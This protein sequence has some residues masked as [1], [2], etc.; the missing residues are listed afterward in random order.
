MAEY[1][2][3][4]EI[5]DLPSKGHFYVQGHPLSS[6]KVEIKYMT[7]K[8]EDILTSQNLI[9]KGVVIEKLLQSLIVDKSIKIEDLLIGDK[10]AIMVA[11]RV[12]GYGKNYQFTYDGEEQSCD[13]TS[14][15]PVD[16]DFSK[17]PHGKNQFEY[18]LPNS[19]RDIT[20]KLLTGA[21][22]NEIDKE[23]KAL[24]KIS[25]EQGFELTTRL[26]YMITS[27]D[28]KSEPSYINNFV[29]NEFLSVDSFEFRKYL[30]SITPDMDM[31]TTITDSNGKEQVITVPVTVRFFWPSAGI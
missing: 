24:E 8:E 17:F 1:K 30:S 21:D 2:F 10:N 19:E 13:L 20:F 15:E 25:K 23:I 11:A 31:S 28:G 9:Q 12:L 29:E 26:K 7:A 6:G 5:V 16:I 27:V 4:T 18:K 22:E 3:P 14:L